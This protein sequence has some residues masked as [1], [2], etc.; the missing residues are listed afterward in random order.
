VSCCDTA[1]QDVCYKKQL[2]TALPTPA[3]TVFN[4]PYSEVGRGYC[5]QTE[6][7]E[8]ANRIGSWVYAPNQSDGAIACT[9]EPLCQGYHW[10]VGDSS[11]VL[12]SKVGEWTCCETSKGDICM[13]RNNEYGGP[14]SLAD[15]A[16]EGQIVFSFIA[17]NVDF[18]PVL[19]SFN[20]AIKEAVALEAGSDISAANVEVTTS[21]GQ[22]LTVTVTP[23]LGVRAK[24][25]QSNLM[26]ST[27][28]AQ[29][30]K[31][32]IL[33]VP[34]IEGQISGEVGIKDMTRPT[35]Q[36]VFTGL[37]AHYQLN[38]HWEAQGEVE[39]KKIAEKEA[40]AAAA[41]ATPSPTNPRPVAPGTYF[42]PR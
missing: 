1:N 37:T 25:V 4:I 31:E 33:A 14:G 21:I 28:L 19:A 38:E 20:T 30:L 39:A 23:P 40:A 41:S 29:S 11:Y 2:V 35:M 26:S 12:L 15:G 9:I 32:M 3:P 17:E 5:G 24:L 10:N 8:N 27:T 18:L 6:Q 13:K 36:A 7:E 16:P 22:V 42:A 34:N